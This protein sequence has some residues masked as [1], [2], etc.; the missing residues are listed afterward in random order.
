MN[1]AEKEVETVVLEEEENSSP[2]METDEPQKEVNSSSSV[3]TASVVKE[4]ISSSGKENPTCIFYKRNKCQFGISGKGCKYYHPKMCQKLLSHGNGQL[5]GC[6]KGGKCQYF[7]PPMCSKSLSKR[8]CTNLDCVYMHIKGTKRSQTPPPPPPVHDAREKLNRKRS[9][10]DG[11]EKE[12]SSSMENDQCTG[13]TGNV[14]F[15]EKNLAPPKPP[16]GNGSGGEQNQKLME[17]LQQ[18]IMIQSQ[19]I[20]LLQQPQQ[21]QMNPQMLLQTQ[22]PVIQQQR[23]LHM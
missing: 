10:K 16:I 20:Q 7:H 18:L 15:L 12:S 19:Q 21:L 9:M 3:E 2:R 5:K 23:N 22:L 8:I 6:N 17:L 1:V 11:K 13:E 14:P 4:N